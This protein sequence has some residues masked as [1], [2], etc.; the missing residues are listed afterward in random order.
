MG[1]AHPGA[2]TAMG[3]G[4]YFIG[5]LTQPDIDELGRILAKLIRANEAAIK[6]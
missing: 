6:P 3:I 1:A 5:P 2:R 4:R